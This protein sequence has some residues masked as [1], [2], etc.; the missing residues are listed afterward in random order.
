MKVEIDLSD[1]YR[2]ED[3]P[4]E[5]H[6]GW[7]V[8]MWLATR[9]SGIFACIYWTVALL[10]V[11]ALSIWMGILRVKI[12]VDL[13]CAPHHGINSLRALARKYE[14]GRIYGFDPCIRKDRETTARNIPVTLTRSAAWLYDG[15]VIFHV[16]RLGLARSRVRRLRTLLRLLGVAQDDAQARQAHRE[17]GHRGR[18]GT[19]ARSA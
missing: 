1:A 6:P 5:F 19:A 16:G 18:R 2:D 13:G 14:P 7:T 12:V 3:E 9:A 8:P 10:G 4:Y 15:T 17:D 11:G